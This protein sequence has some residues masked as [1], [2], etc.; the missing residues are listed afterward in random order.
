LHQRLVYI[1]C[2]II[3][4]N[5]LRFNSYNTCLCFETDSLTLGPLLSRNHRLSHKPMSTVY[6][7]NTLGGKP[8]VS[9][10]V[11]T[12]LLLICS[13]LLVWFRTSSFTTYNL[14]SM[15]LVAHLTRC[16]RSKLLKRLLLLYTIINSGCKFS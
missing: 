11:S 3:M 6:S 12:Y 1:A 8:F 15:C 7:L 14:M 16:Q 9:R 13:I 2:F 4:F 5:R 10:S